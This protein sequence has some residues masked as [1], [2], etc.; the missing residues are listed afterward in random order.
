MRALAMSGGGVL[1]AYE[2]GA[3]Q[4]LLKDRKTQYDLYA[5]TSVGAINAVALAMFKTGEEA[6][7]AEHLHDLWWNLSN[8]NVR[9]SWPLG[10]LQGALFEQAAYNSRPLRDF[11][12][13]RI[14]AAK[15][16]ASKKKLRLGTVRLTEGDYISCTESSDSLLDAVL[17][18]SAFPGFLLP[19]KIGDSFCVDGG[20]RNVT[21]LADAITAGATEIDVIVTLPKDKFG[22]F[23]DNPKTLDIAERA[24]SIQNAEVMENDLK[25]AELYNQLALYVPDHVPGKR[26]VKINVLRPT[27]QPWDGNGLDFNTD[28]IRNMIAKGYADA[29]SFF[30]TR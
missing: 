28:A 18:S 27:E 6:Q 22:G 11:L 30:A 12:A 14:D 15:V 17:A 9:K 3:I 23:K 29:K 13:P 1:G 25:I 8:A 5:G 10:M 19:V 21:P 2:V 26:W 16:K 4:Y 20:V 7:A 24:L